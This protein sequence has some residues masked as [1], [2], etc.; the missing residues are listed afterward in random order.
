[1]KHLGMVRIG[2]LII[3]EGAKEMAYFWESKPKMEIFRV[4]LTGGDPQWLPRQTESRDEAG[5][6]AE[7]IGAKRAS[8][9]R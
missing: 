3:E 9:R 7:P 2:T 4:M 5:A 8:P 6:P 1:M